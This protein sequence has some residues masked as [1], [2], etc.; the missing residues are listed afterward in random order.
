MRTRERKRETHAHEERERRMEEGAREKREGSE[1]RMGEIQNN[2]RS[3]AKV[4]G[5]NTTAN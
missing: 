3:E 2:S 5:D 4:K 1:S